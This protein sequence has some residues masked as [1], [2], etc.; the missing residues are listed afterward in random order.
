MT[1]VFPA[2]ELGRREEQETE[3]RSGH[4]HEDSLDSGA[5]AVAVGD[6][7][8]GLRGLEPCRHETVGG[9]SNDESGES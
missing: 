2:R 3:L 1:H 6:R 4:D 5:G 8:T 7:Q 9:Q